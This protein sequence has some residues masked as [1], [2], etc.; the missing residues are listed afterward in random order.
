M[1][2]VETGPLFQEWH[3]FAVC[4]PTHERVEVDHAVEAG[5]V[6]NPVVEQVSLVF[7][8]R[9]P[10]AFAGTR[11]DGSADDLQTDIVSPIDQLLICGYQSGCVNVRGEVVGAFEKDHMC[12]PFANQDVVVESKPGRQSFPSV[13]DSVTRDS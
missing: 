3:A 7:S 4:R 5:S 13:E 10:G 6:A 12:N 2:V 8:R 11:K 1:D 9:I